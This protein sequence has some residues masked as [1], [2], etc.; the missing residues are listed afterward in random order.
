MSAFIFERMILFG[1]SE[2]LECGAGLCAAV[3]VLKVFCRV[4]LD[5]ELDVGVGQ[6]FGGCLK[7][8]EGFGAVTGFVGGLG[9]AECC[10]AGE[11]ALGFGGVEVLFVVEERGVDEIGPTE[12]FGEMEQGGGKVCGLRVFRDEGL[13]FGFGFFELVAGVESLCDVEREVFLTGRGWRGGRGSWGWGSGGFLWR[14]TSGSGFEEVALRS[15]LGGG[16]RVL[17]GCGGDR[18]DGCDGRLGWECGRVGGGR[19]EWGGFGNGATYGG[20]FRDFGCG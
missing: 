8:G 10:W 12:C 3:E 4:E 6:V 9:E 17:G 15:W 16:E 2:F 13:E 1:I 7:V 20:R 5:D 11:G 18:I 19:V 14:G